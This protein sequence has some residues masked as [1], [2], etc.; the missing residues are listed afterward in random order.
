[1]VAFVRSSDSRHGHALA[2]ELAV[3]RKMLG[4]LEAK[5][6]ES[7]ADHFPKEDD[8]ELRLALQRIDDNRLTQLALDYAVC[9]RGLTAPM[10]S[11]AWK[12]ELTEDVEEA[13]RLFLDRLQRL[14]RLARSP[15]GRLWL[16]LQ[17]CVRR[18]FR[19]PPH[20]QRLPSVKENGNRGQLL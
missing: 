1:M 19:K 18:V 8:R 16:R 14:E 10:I 3:V 7:D 5:L 13:H 6:L 20:S 4:R 9:V 2:Q 15:V 12:Q 11:R 17:A